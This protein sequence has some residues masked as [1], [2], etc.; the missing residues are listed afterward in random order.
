[1]DQQ[2]HIAPQGGAV[3]LVIL[4]IHCRVGAAIRG[5][6]IELDYRTIA[7]GAFSNRRMILK[8]QI[9]SNT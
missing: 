5:V 9:V 1:M 4:A 7:V 8:R 3:P 2:F 6:R